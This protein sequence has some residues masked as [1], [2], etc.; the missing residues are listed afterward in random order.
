MITLEFILE[1]VVVAL[2]LTAYT[3]YVNLRQRKKMR[4][5]LGDK[6]KDSVK[7]YF[8]HPY[9]SILTNFGIFLVL[10]ALLKLLHN[11]IF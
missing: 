2:V 11:I 9:L 1:S 10:T 3:S 7:F 6:C 4:E 5:Q 8:K